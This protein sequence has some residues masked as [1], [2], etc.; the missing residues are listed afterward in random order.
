MIPS[1]KINKYMICFTI[2]LQLSF[3]EEEKRL[4]RKHTSYVIAV[5]NIYRTVNLGFFFFPVA[6]I[7]PPDRVDLRIGHLPAWGS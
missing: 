2:N 3:K 4:V 7:D 1:L 6:F 5:L